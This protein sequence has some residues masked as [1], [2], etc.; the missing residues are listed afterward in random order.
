MYRSGMSQ[1]DERAL[2]AEIEVLERTHGQVDRSDQ[3]R[4]HAAREQGAL[5]LRQSRPDLFAPIYR[6]VWDNGW[7]SGAFPEEY[8]DAGAAEDAGDDWVAEMQ[9]YDEG[10]EYTFE[11]VEESARREPQT[12]PTLA[13]PKILYGPTDDERAQEFAEAQGAHFDFLRRLPR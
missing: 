8:G 2:L 1:Q 13:G 12:R 6:V 3:R 7:D 11:V 5:R 9:A 4:R 10:G